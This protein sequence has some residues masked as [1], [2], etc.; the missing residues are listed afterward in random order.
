[1]YARSGQ[2]E[3]GKFDGAPEMI[4]TYD[5][6]TASCNCDNPEYRIGEDTRLATDAPVK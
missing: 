3:K 1:M 6:G 5:A 4:S 2:T